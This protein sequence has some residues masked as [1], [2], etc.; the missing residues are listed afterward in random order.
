MRRVI[1]IDFETFYSGK[2][3]Y[4]LRTMIAETY[5]KHPL[6]DPYLLSVC[7]GEST[8]VG[9]PRDFNW[10]ALD[11]AHVVAHN[12]YFDWQVWCEMAAR[13]WC[14][15]PQPASVNCTANLTAYIAN[16]RALDHAVEFLHG[17]KLSKTMRSNADGK[18]WKDF[19]P[20][21]QKAM[22]E[23]AGRDSFWCHKL[24]TDYSPKW[25][26]DEQRLSWRNIEQGIRGL[27]ID[28]DL[29]NSYL[30]WSHE[31][32]MS[33]EK[34]I[35]WIADADDEA[36]DDFNAKPTSTK[37]IAE[38]CRL[39]GIPCPPVKRDDPEA[40]DEWEETYL[41]K[42]PWIQSLTAWRS[43]NKLYRTCETVKSRIRPDGTIPFELKY[44]GAHTGRWSGAARFNL[45][46][47][48]R[49]PT[50][51]RSSDGLMEQDDLKV[52]AL[53]EDFKA[54]G[55]WGDPVHHAIDLRN[56]VVARPGKKMISSDLSQIE[57][58]VLAFF[59][60]DKTLMERVKSG[61][62]IYEVHARMTMGWKGGKLKNEN[63]RIYSLAKAREL[64]LG[65]GCAWKK[66]IVVARTMASIDITVDDPEW[67]DEVGWDGKVKRVPG[68]GFTSK[69]NVKDY[70]TNRP[71][72]VSFWG[73]LDSA[74]KCSI[75][76]DFEMVL[77]SGRIMRYKDVR[78]SVK[79]EPDPE[80]GKPRRK[81]IVTADIGGVRYP[82]YGGLLTENLVQAT[83]RDVF[84][85]HLNK[86]DD[87]GLPLLFSSH[88][89]AII[90]ADSDVKASDVAAIMSE[91]PPWLGMCP[92]AAEAKEIERYCK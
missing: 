20:D 8:W 9:A 13:G 38:Q 68:Y 26:V 2:L 86:L 84:A 32:K 89:E 75:G 19:S 33:A 35:P 7:D 57:P 40:Y 48:K 87:A 14:P 22:R 15:A 65:F 55:R 11:G 47:M 17:V 44:F 80:T 6:F 42:H 3:K 29:L 67:V 43:L 5:V 72:V 91:T 34:T 46:N 45:Q 16:R 88:D 10:A 39:S 69:Q 49:L 73:R 50:I 59:V 36:W 76:S 24:W 41:P 63:P 83:A 12:A 52:D 70:R 28:K 54:K 30:L 18:S 62:S 60:G 56:I 92:I 79:I 58:R 53:V 66:F 85:F 71:H 1:A 81:N 82:L 74:L 31:A 21:D 23:Y 27:Q 4:T 78:A 77:P 25:P 37:C 61:E 51:V 90:E 64:G